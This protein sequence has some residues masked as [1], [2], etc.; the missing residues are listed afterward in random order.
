VTLSDNG[1]GGTFSATNYLLDAS[2]NRTITG[3]YTPNKAGNA[4][5]TANF[6][7]TGDKTVDIFVSPYSTTIGFIGD[8]V[9]AGTSIQNYVPNLLG[10]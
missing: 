2:N 6:A 1:A 4:T 9:T 8:S 3:T 5:L 7:S 10:Q